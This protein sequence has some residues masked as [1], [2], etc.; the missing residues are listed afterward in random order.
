MI[1]KNQHTFYLN[2]QIEKKGVMIFQDIW[3]QKRKQCIVIMLR[4]AQQ[5]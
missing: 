5:H 2:I 1:S 4:M 3:L